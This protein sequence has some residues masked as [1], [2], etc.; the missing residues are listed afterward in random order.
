MKTV[1]LKPWQ[2][3]AL[4]VILPTALT[5]ILFAGSLFFYTLPR[6]EGL[7]YEDHKKFIREMTHIV[8]NLA[9]NYQSRVES[10]ELSLPE[11]QNRFKE[12]LRVMHYGRENRDYFWIHDLGTSYMI[13]H[14]YRPDLEGQ[15]VYD[16][17]DVSG[18]YLTREFNAMA[19]QPDGGYVEYLWQWHDDPDRI[20]PK[21]AYVHRIEPWGWVVGT[22]IYVEE[23]RQEIA[24][25]TTEVHRNT[26]FI[27]LIVAALCGYLIWHGV[28]TEMAR[29]T[30]QE[31]LQ[32]SFERF[33]TVLDSLDTIIYVSDLETH[34][35]LFVNKCGRQKASGAQGRYC[36]QVLHLD[37]TAPCE[38]CHLQALMRGAAES[39]THVRQIHDP[40]RSR[41][42]ECRDQLI[43]WVDGRAVCL[44][45]ATDI[46]DRKTAEQDREDLMK[47][48]SQKNEELQSIVYAASH[49]LRSP[50]INIQGFASELGN[51]CGR[52]TELL[53]RPQGA[54]MYQTIVQ[55]ILEEE[56]PESLDFIH[57]NTEKMQT[58]V[59]GLLQLSRIG[60]AKLQFR[61]LDMNALMNDVLSTCGY[62]I[63]TIGAD[64]KVEPLLPA[65]GDSNQINQVFSNLVD[66]ALKYRRQDRPLKMTIRSRDVDGLVEYAV[67]DNGIGIARMHLHR[68][69]ELFQQLKPAGGAAE[70]VGLGLTIVKRIID[71]HNGSIRVESIPGEG[72]TFY[73]TLPK[74]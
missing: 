67:S 58:L 50:L 38:S 4:H 17:Q 63:K 37:Q 57:K 61:S 28:R 52:L 53:R 1:I 35:V 39:S 34:E 19:R 41:W 45:V 21:I 70:G 59:N 43:R 72:S 31:D 44:E 48:L 5:V 27:F 40:Q 36:W 11:A 13:M 30:A 24:T 60:T 12:R 62:Q 68:I 3:I 2:R 23:L 8:L 7:L 18:K 14:P 54:A 26:A 65:W 55:T 66:N 46:T 15:N 9:A 20:M 51:A 64:I 16:L 6:F 49:D 74:G 33:K 10:G 25:L 47:K 32:E 73:V 22:G 69:F 29:Q 42:Y 71:I 56:L